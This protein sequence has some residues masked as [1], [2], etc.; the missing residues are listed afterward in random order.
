MLRFKRRIGPWYCVRERRNQQN[1]LARRS[2]DFAKP[3]G[4]RF[5]VSFATAVFH[6]LTHK[7]LSKVFLPICLSRAH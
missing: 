1:P 7:I 4:R 3:I 2:P 5:T 6:P